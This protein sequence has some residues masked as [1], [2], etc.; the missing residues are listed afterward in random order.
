[1][2]LLVLKSISSYIGFIVSCNS[3]SS[4]WSFLF[5]RKHSI[6]KHVR[7]KTTMMQNSKAPDVIKIPTIKV[8]C[9]GKFVLL[10]I[11]TLSS[12]VTSYLIVF[13]VLV[14]VATVI[15]AV[16]DNVKFHVSDSFSSMG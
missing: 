9:L 1:M 3:K 6:N 14:D 13:E 10:E 12:T 8:I 11:S 5:E 2:F 16:V 15:V 4:L 7:I